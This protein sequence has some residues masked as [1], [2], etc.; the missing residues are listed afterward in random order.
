LVVAV[1]GVGVLVV[2]L[3]GGAVSGVAVLSVG[4]VGV[5]AGW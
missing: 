4:V 2:R 3:L 5:C 1:S